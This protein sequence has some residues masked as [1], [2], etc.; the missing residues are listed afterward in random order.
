MLDLS[1]LVASTGQC[2]EHGTQA[3][4]GRRCIDVLKAVGFKQG[5]AS[6]C[7]ARHPSWSVSAVDH[8]D[9]F[10]ALGTTKGL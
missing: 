6:P 1:S 2:M 8:G 7:G 10:T 4:S 5:V 9:D 3:C